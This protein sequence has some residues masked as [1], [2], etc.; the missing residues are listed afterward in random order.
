MYSGP[1]YQ[2]TS[3][4][5]ASAFCTSPPKTERYGSGLR[6]CTTPVIPGSAGQRRVVPPPRRRPRRRPADEGPRLGGLCPLVEEG[7]GGFAGWF[8]F[9]SPPRENVV[10]W[11][12]WGAA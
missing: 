11:G 3:S 4:T 7:G 5:W 12:A 9:L 10:L 2:I 6:K 8:L 1:S